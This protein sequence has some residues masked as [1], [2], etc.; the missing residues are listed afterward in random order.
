MLICCAPARNQQVGIFFSS[1]PDVLNSVA[2][3]EKWN[4]LLATSGNPGNLEP[5]KIKGGRDPA[6]NRMYY[7]FAR[8]PDGS[9]KL[10]QLLVRREKALF[11]DES[12]PEIVRCGCDASFNLEWDG[13]EW[14]CFSQEGGECET[15]IVGK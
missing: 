6:G 1:R 14:V 4:N 5:V 11:V 9:S 10:A 3:R 13:I 15:Q 8:T 2:L 7:L 12:H